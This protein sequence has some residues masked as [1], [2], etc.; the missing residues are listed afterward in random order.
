MYVAVDD[1][2]FSTNGLPIVSG[3]SVTSADTRGLPQVAVVSEALARL[4]ADGGDPIGHRISDWASLRR[5]MTGRGP[6]DYA[7]IVGV[8]PDL[9]TDVNTIEKLTVYHPLPSTALLGLSGT[10]LVVRAGSNASVAMRETV[11]TARALDPRVTL[12]RVMTLSE[13]IGRQMQ[14]QRFGIYILGVLGGTALLLTVLGTY[15]LAE[16][17]LGSRRRELSIRA[18]LGARSAQLRSVVLRDVARLVGIGL[19]AGLVLAV[20]GARLIR[21]LL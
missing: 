4:I 21:S 8:V 11:A 18:A 3:R 17:M 10:T 7:E 9:I 13:Q 16:S 1:D 12:G 6:P 14:P 2:F 19:I 15:V 5:V 20:L